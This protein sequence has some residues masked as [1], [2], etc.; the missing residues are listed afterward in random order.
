MITAAAAGRSASRRERQRRR[1]PQASS[2]RG[3]LLR[4]AMLRALRA[5]FRGSRRARRA[6]S[7]LEVV[8]QRVPYFPRFATHHFADILA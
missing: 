4:R 7:F 6:I 5:P 2:M 1:R 3:R 8:S